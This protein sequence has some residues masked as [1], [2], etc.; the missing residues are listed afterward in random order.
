MKK[1][2]NYCK[3]CDVCDESAKRVMKKG[4]MEKQAKEDLTKEFAASVAPTADVEA[5]RQKIIDLKREFVHETLQL[6]TRV[7][8]LEEEVV[9]LNVRL[10]VVTGQCPKYLQVLNADK[11]MVERL[12]NKHSKAKRRS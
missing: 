2:S 5:L 7:R 12:A 9:K 8:T 3:A 10:G 6:Q 1:K 4:R 11:I